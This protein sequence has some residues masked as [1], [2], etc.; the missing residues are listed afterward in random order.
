MYY[1]CQDINYYRCKSR[2]VGNCLVEVCDLRVLF[3]LEFAVEET[4]KD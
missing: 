2:Y 4:F 1:Y 3:N